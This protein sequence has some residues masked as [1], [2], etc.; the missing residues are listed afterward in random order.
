MASFSFYIVR[1]KSGLCRNSSKIGKKS[2]FDSE[3]YLRILRFQKNAVHSTIQRKSF[4]INSHDASE[5]SCI[6][7]VFY[8]R[9]IGL[10]SEYHIKLF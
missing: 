5:H 7:Q 6:T 9:W 4:T 1:D 8:L 2:L 3:M 10:S